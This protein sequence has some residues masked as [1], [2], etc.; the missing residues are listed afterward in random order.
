LNNQVADAKFKAGHEI[1]NT[2]PAKGIGLITEAAKDK[3]NI[4]KNEI[5]DNRVE[6]TSLRFYY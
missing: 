4:V 5:F 3:N 1:L 2:D 6:S